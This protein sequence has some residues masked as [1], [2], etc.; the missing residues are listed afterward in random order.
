MVHFFLSHFILFASFATKKKRNDSHQINRIENNTRRK[1]A[2]VKIAIAVKMKMNAANEISRKI[3]K[4][5]SDS[6]NKEKKI[7]NDLWGLG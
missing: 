5:S 4:Q 3:E 6:K 2:K 1:A 7:R